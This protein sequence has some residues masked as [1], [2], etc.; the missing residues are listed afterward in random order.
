MKTNILVII[1]ILIY[2]GTTYNSHKFDEIITWLR[3]IFLSKD[4]KRIANWW[5]TD[6]KRISKGLIIEFVL[7][8]S[9]CHPSDILLRTHLLSFC[10]PIRYPFSTRSEFSPLKNYEFCWTAVLCLLWSLTTPYYNWIRC[11]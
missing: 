11:Q 5:Q 6:C 2:Y 3:R 7:L 8:L 9:F 4:R 1:F 10:D